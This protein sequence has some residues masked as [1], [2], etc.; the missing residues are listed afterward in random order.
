MLGK[1]RDQAGSWFFKTFLTLIAL[2]FILWGV[3]E[4]ATGSFNST[5]I[6]VNDTKIPAQAVSRAYQA[7]LRN[8]EN[9]VGSELTDVHKQQI[10]LGER[11]VMSI[12][13]ETLLTDYA[14]NLDIRMANE[15]LDNVL[16]NMKNFHNAEAKCDQN[17]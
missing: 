3:G 10:R 5:A 15:H 4:I 13:T 16:R 17:V 1:I 9:R 12:I 14:S 8:M 11:T 2:S 6:T 7:A